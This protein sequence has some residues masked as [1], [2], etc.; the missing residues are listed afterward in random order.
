MT[1]TPPPSTAAHKLYISLPEGVAPPPGFKTSSYDSDISKWIY[2]RVPTA[3]SC[4]SEAAGNR[5]CG[6]WCYNE[7]RCTASFVEVPGLDVIHDSDCALH[8]APAFPIGPCNC[9][10]S[11]PSTAASEFTDAE[12]A[13][14]LKW[15]DLAHARYAC[16]RIDDADREIELNA[17]KI[18]RYLLS[19]LSAGSESAEVEQL[20]REI[21]HHLKRGA[22]TAD[23]GLIV[24]LRC[25]LDHVADDERLS[26]GEGGPLVAGEG[27]PLVADLEQ[28]VYEM[29]EQI[30]GG[31]ECKGRDGHIS[32]NARTIMSAAGLIKRQANVIDLWM[33]NWRKSND[34]LGRTQ[35]KL[36]EAE[37]DALR[38][39]WL[40]V[41]Y[42]YFTKVGL[43]A[44]IDA[45]LAADPSREG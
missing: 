45:A 26:A 32:A 4:A 35:A 6:G 10:V 16:E 24:N 37:R 3:W 15:L 30:D 13:D 38:Y 9:S 42:P 2:Q 34:E 28:I 12:I 25:I 22:E 14:A 40:K 1:D 7:S 20:V 27:G 44:A 29:L 11:K 17:A 5:R 41:E 31:E 19:R 39:R 23:H 18:I 43:D 8:N 36:A 21:H 33:A